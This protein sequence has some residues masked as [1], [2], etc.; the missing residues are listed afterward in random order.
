LFSALGALLML[1]LLLSTIVIY[2]SVNQMLLH[3]QI[4]PLVSFKCF[5]YKVGEIL[6]KRARIQEC[7]ATFA[8]EPEWKR[9]PELCQRR[10][11]CNIKMHR[12]GISLVSRMHSSFS[13]EGEQRAVFFYKERE[14]LAGGLS[15]ICQ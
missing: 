7:I 2:F 13:R 9:P 12:K 3:Q 14:F 6:I 10:K 15:F 5:D 11:K 8:E 1:L 4:I